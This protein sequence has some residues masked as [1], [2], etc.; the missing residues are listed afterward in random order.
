MQGCKVY[1]LS[2]TLWKSPA[3]FDIGN[4]SYISANQ[5]EVA[6]TF[7]RTSTFAVVKTTRIAI[8]CDYSK[9]QIA[10]SLFKLTS[11][12]K[13]AQQSQGFGLWASEEVY[14]LGGG[15][16]NALLEKPG[17][18]RHIGLAK[19]DESTEIGLNCFTIYIPNVLHPL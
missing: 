15:S 11:A 8:N 4:T 2:H 7:G 9:L 19:R 18:E 12:N 1:G 17:K 3:G 16:G 10:V 13:V 14:R 5:S 6:Q